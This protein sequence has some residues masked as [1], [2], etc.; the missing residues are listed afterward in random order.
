MEYCRDGLVV[1]AAVIKDAVPQQCRH[2]VHQEQYALA[3]EQ[4]LLHHYKLD[5]GDK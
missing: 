1:L 2:E 3:L 5:I 4:M